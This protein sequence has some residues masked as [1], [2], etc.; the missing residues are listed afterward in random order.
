M[1]RWLL[2]IG[3]L[4][5]GVI[6]VYAAYAKLRAP[7]IEFAGSLAAFQLLPE[8]LLEPIARTLPTCE[9]L[10]GLALISGIWQRWFSLIASLLLLLFFSV[11]VRS[12]AMGLQI[13]CGCF[14]PGEALG[15]KTL[16]RDF[17]MLALA[18]AVTIGSFRMKRGPE[19]V[20]SSPVVA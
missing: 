13:D 8:N 1:K 15:P 12:Y 18:V 19:P 5:L 16:A 2:V 17:S 7:W 14:G 6:F 3:R 20:P 4:I 10:L 9:L 11:M